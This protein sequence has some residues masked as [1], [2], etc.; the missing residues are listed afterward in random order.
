MGCIESSI[1]HRGNLE[2]RPQLPDEVWI[3]IFGYLDLKTI[4]FV[5]SF[6][7]KRWLTIVRNDIGLSG[8]LKLS[9]EII[10]KRFHLDV[11]KIIFDDSDNISESVEHQKFW[12]CLSAWPKI[13]KIT[14]QSAEDEEDVT[15]Y[16]TLFPSLKAFQEKHVLQLPYLQELEIECYFTMKPYDF[17]ATYGLIYTLEDQS[18]VFKT[19]N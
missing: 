13:Q 10:K 9:E 18:Q 12:R 4:H 7:C 3:K 16:L 15:T 17:M 1:F 6:V 19:R 14:F 8:N 2:N 11:P 5:V